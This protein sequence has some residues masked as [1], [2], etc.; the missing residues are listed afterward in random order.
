MQPYN[1]IIIFF[2]NGTFI[3]TYP[4]SDKNKLRAFERHLAKQNREYDLYKHIL[5]ENNKKVVFS[6]ASSSLS[7]TTELTFAQKSNY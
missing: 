6:S 7:A 2:I 5:L 1:I 4:F 3:Q